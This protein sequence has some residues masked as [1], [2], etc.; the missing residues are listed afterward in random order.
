MKT[1]EI[2]P[3]R[4]EL[5]TWRDAGSDQDDMQWSGPE[6]IR[7]DNPIIQSIGWVVKETTANLTIAMDYCEA[8]G[9]THTRSRIPQGMIVSRQ[10]LITIKKDDE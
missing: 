9:T 1:E 4:M 6:D 8:D 5:V 7:D 10:I 2:K 3:L